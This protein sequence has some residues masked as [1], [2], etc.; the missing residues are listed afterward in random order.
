MDATCAVVWQ[1]KFDGGVIKDITVTNNG[2]VICLVKKNNE[3]FI[4]KY[5]NDGKG[6]S[7][8]PVTH[9]K[10]E[11]AEYNLEVNNNNYYI[12]SLYGQT[13]KSYKPD[14]GRAGEKVRFQSRGVQINLFD[15]VLNEASVK[16]YDYADQTLLDAVESIKL[17]NIKGVDWVTYDKLFFT[18]NGGM[19]IVLEKKYGYVKLKTVSQGKPPVKDFYTNYGHLSNR[20]QMHDVVSVMVRE[21]FLSQ[22]QSIS[23]C[24][25]KKL[26]RFPVQ[27]RSPFWVLPFNSKLLV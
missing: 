19:Y 11:N 15:S 5:A 10:P 18:D 7:E 9:I 20:R 12:V 6:Y 13:D 8:K 25:L 16:Y 4:I 3:H 14:Y 22:I 23:S 27:S 21:E 24:S 26:S 2:D 17:Q 1:Q